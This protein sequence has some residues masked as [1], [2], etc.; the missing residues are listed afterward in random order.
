MSC[1]NNYDCGKMSFAKGKYFRRSSAFYIFGLES[2]N[3]TEAGRA[4]LE[5]KMPL[6]FQLIP[7]QMWAGQGCPLGIAVASDLE[8]WLPITVEKNPSFN[9]KAAY[10]MV[11]VIKG[12][13]KN[14][15]NPSHLNLC[16]L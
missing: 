15:Q 4:V 6:E 9:T 1:K 13:V 3:R 7:I 14:F 8:L 2:C 10:I 5:R 16:F 11:L 12:N